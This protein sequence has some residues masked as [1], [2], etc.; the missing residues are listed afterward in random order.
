MQE[1]RE[2]PGWRRRQCH[3][4]YYLREQWAQ[5]ADRYLMPATAAALR[6]GRG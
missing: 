4:P 3:V 1:W 6:K 2:I 5:E